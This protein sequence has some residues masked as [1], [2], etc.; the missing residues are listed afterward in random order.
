[1]T[2]YFAGLDLSDEEFDLILK[3]SLN[4]VYEG[5]VNIDEVK[6]KIRESIINSKDQDFIDAAQLLYSEIGAWDPRLQKSS[7]IWGY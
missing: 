7:K 2:D 6:E 4:I 1:M 3:A 5:K